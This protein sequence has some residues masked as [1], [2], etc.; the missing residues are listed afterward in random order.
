M[1]KQAFEMTPEERERAVYIIGNTVLMLEEGY[2]FDNI[3][4]KLNLKQYQVCENIY[5]ILYHIRRR[6]G[7]WNFF[8]SLFIK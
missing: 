1:K 5:E 6:I 2:S 4:K 8:R 7:K 3:S